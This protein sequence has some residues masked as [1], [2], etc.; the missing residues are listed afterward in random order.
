MPKRDEELWRNIKVKSSNLVLTCPYCSSRNISKLT[1]DF[2]REE[3]WKC[4]GCGSQFRT[5]LALVMSGT[6]KT[7]SKG[8]PILERKE[9]N[10]KATTS[11]K[12]L[13]SIR[14]KYH[15]K[16]GVPRPNKFPDLGRGILFTVAL[17]SKV[18]LY[19]C[20]AVSFVLALHGLIIF[21]SSGGRLLASFTTPRWGEASEEA[22]QLFAN[23]TVPWEPLSNLVGW[24][25][26]HSSSLVMPLVLLVAAGGLYF[27]ARRLLL[28]R[29]NKENVLALA[30]VV[31]IG[32][33]VWLALGAPIPAM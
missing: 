30:L 16:E 7:F 14:R 29:G 13:I 10:S 32:F 31:I 12:P 25:T 19:L 8:Y 2:E 15:Y 21:S 33:I 1:S 18:V 23:V 26:A 17:L 22:K 28:P 11:K 3:R 20:S 24:M 6:G 27:A 5:P 9:K 4:N